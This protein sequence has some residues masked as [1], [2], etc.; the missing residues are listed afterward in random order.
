M[1]KKSIQILVVC[2]ATLLATTSLNAQQ[3]ITL[4]NGNEINV[5]SY[6][7]GEMFVNYKLAGDQPKKL[8]LV[9]KFDVFSVTDANN[10]EEVLYKPADSLDFSVEE[11]RVYM[12][13]ERA[14]HNYFD[15]TGS[16]V[17]SMYVGVA[18][19]VLGFYSVPLP[20]LYSM[21]MARKS[22]KQLPE[23]FKNYE[24]NEAFKFGYNR[25]A[26]TIKF[27]QGLKFGYISLGVSLTM[28]VFLT[29]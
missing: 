10:S 3:K 28:L 6:S 7:I 8:R 22:P 16:S 19:G 25:E 20:F 23:E 2:M 27:K 21:T 17:S 4:L 29:K 11:A 15:K 5:T 14:A 13:G 12:E 24:N 9:D 26:R 1:M 18:S